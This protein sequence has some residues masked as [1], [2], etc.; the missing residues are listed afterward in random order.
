MTED[1]WKIVSADCREGGD[2]GI[3]PFKT[4]VL[5]KKDKLQHEAAKQVRV[6]FREKWQNKALTEVLAEA[7]TLI[8]RCKL[9]SVQFGLLDTTNAWIVKPASKSRGR[10]IKCFSRLDEI[11]E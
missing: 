1:E 9:H 8:A 10:G 11:I 5:K 6:S 4:P 2:P 7:R 3:S